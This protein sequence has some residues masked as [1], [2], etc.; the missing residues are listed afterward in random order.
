MKKN[1][2]SRFRGLEIT[3]DNIRLDEFFLPPDFDTSTL[4]YEPV[5]Y[6]KKYGFKVIKALSELYPRYNGIVSE[7]YIPTSIYYYY[8]MPYLVNMNLSMA[9]VDKNMYFQHLPTV[10]QPETVVHNLHGRY[11]LPKLEKEI[12]LA[13]AVRLLQG[14]E[15]VIIKPAIE[16]GAGRDVRLLRC[17]EVSQC[18]C[19]EILKSYQSDFIVQRV[20]RQ[21]AEMAR[22]NPTSL[23]TCRVYTYRCVESG[24]Y[25]VLGAAVRFGGKGA[26][27][28]NACAG[29]GFCRINPDGS[30]ADAIYHYRSFENG[31]L[32]ALKGIEHFKIPNYDGV[33]ETCLSSHRRIPYMDLIG[34]DIAIAEDGVPALVELNQYPDCEM[35]QIVNGPM[36]G[37]HTDALMERISK[38]HLKDVVVYKRSFDDLP[39]TCDYNFEIG[40][41]YTI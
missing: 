24:E 4:S 27:R 2:L 1:P 23:N 16:S 11:F 38:H 20:L 10:R 41:A 5:D 34:W 33:I 19:E 35:L 36:F 7:K 9:Y 18:E 14:E 37:E 31:S 28:D 25:V 6:F 13:D 22:L 26:H 8:I 21:H 39:H 32:K 3:M 15:S 12:T 29:G 40:K 30:V 17:R